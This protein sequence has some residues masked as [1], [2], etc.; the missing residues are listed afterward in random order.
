M[1]YPKGLCAVFKKKRQLIKYCNCIVILFFLFNPFTN[2]ASHIVGGEMSYRCIG[3]NNFEI[4]LTIY[5]DCYNATQGTLFDNP[6][7]IG[8]F[9]DNDSL[10]LDLMGLDS[11]QMLIPSTFSDT[12][13]IILSDPCL[14]PPENICI[15]Y[16][17]YIDT[18]FLDPDII[19]GGVQLT[20]QRCCRN[21]QIANV[22]ESD[23]TGISIVANISDE[24]IQTC[25]SSPQFS[26]LP[27]VFVCV[28]EPFVFDQSLTDVDGDSL[29][30]SLCTPLDG[31][32]LLDTRPQPP[33]NPPYD[34]ITWIDPPYNLN[35]LLGGI[36]LTIDPQTGELTATP[37]TIGLF[38]VGLCIEEYRDG[39]LISTTR[40][41][42]QYNV[43][44]CEEVVAEIATPIIE[45]DELEVEFENLSINA[46]EFLWVF[47]D[48]G[49]PN[50]TSFLENP[51]FHFSDT[52]SYTIML[53]AEPNSPCTDT[54][55]IDILLEKS[56]LEADFNH[57]TLECTDSVML[58]LV[59]TSVDSVYSIE[60]WYW[61]LSDGQTSNEQFPLFV[62]DS[63]QQLDV[64]LVVVSENGCEEK[65]EA[66]IFVNLISSNLLEDKHVICDGDS[67]VLN[68]NPPI[69][70]PFIYEWTPNDGLNDPTLASPT[71]SPDMDMDYSLLIIDTISNCF[72]ELETEVVILENPELSIEM[73]GIPCGNE[74]ELTAT[75]NLTQGDFIWATDENF[76]NIISDSSTIVVSSFG[77]TTYYVEFSSSG[78]CIITDSI[79]VQEASIN[80]SL[81]ANSQF[82]CV[83]DEAVFSATNADSL[84]EVTYTWFDGSG[85]VLDFDSLFE[86]STTEV[87]I[88]LFYFQA[89]NQHGCTY[90]DSVFLSAIDPSLPV[91]IQIT[92]SCNSNVV[93]FSNIGANANFYRWIINLPS[94]NDTLLGANIQNYDFVNSGTYE[95]TLV[96][97]PGLPCTLPT[98]TIEVTTGEGVVNA[99]FSWEYIDCQNDLMIQFIDNSSAV[100]GN[101]NSMIWTFGN[102]PPVSSSNP[103]LQLNSSGLV[104]I[105]LI[106]TTD[107][108]CSDTLYQEIDFQLTDIGAFENATVVCSGDGVTLNP[109]GN[110]SLNYEWSPANFLDDANSVSPFA[111]PPTTTI[112]TVTITDPNNPNCV[113]EEMVE[114][115]VP[116]VEVQA[117]F[118]YEI[119]NCDSTSVVLTF[120]DNSTP[121]AIINNW[122][123][124][125]SNGQSSNNPV[126]TIVANDGEVLEVTL[127]V[128][129]EDDCSA[130]IVET[131]VVETFTFNL[132]ES[133][134]IKCTGLPVVLNENGNSNFTYTWTPAATL[135]DPNSP[136]PIANP[137]E[138]TEYC[139]TVFNGECSQESCVTVIVPEVPLM[140]DF[141]YSVSDC[142]DEAVISFQDQSQNSLGNIVEWNWTFSNGT[143]STLENPSITITQD[144]IIEAVL[145]VTTSNGC[146][147]SFSQEVEVNLLNI[148]I[149]SQVVLCE[150]N[151]IQL[152]P[153]GN[154]NHEY[155]WFPGSGLTDDDVAS[156]VAFPTSTTTYTVT[157]TDGD[158]QVVQNVEVIVPTIPLTAGFSFNIEDCTDVAVIDFEDLSEYSPGNIIEWN[159]TFS[160]GDI[161]TGS[162]PSVT[163]DSSQ[164]LGVT[165]EVMTD[166]GCTAVTTQNLDINLI[167]IN[168]APLLV[169]CNG[170]GVELNPAGD[171]TYIYSWSPS[172]GL[173]NTNS[174]NPIANPTSTTLYTV[175]V[176]DGICE[177]TREVEVIVPDE[178][179]QAGFSFSFED[180]TDNAVIEFTDTTIIGNNTISEWN[181]TFTGNDT[182]TFTT[183]NPILTFNQSD[184]IIAELT[185]TTNDGC[186]ATISE[187]IE[188]NLIDINIPTE[189]IYCNTSGIILN[190]NGNP[191]YEYE[192]SPSMGL[193]A[194]NVASPIVSGLTQNMSYS[195][196]VKFGDCIL[197]RNVNVII[198][199]VPVQADFNFTYLTCIDSAT[200]Q[201]ND[202]SQYSG[203]IIEWD[204]LINSQASNEPNPIF[205]FYE[206]QPFNVQLIVTTDNGCRDTINNT[207]FVSLMDN[208]NLPTDTA[209]CNGNGIFLN[210]NSSNPGVDYVW[211]PGIGLSGDTLIANP[212]AN[213]DSSQV[214]T[215]TLTSPETGCVEER[216]IS[217][218][219]PTQPLTAGFEWE[220]SN[221]SDSSVVEFIDTS[222]Y[223]GIL[224]E[225]TWTFDNTNVF[226]E[227]NPD[228]V[229]FNPD[230]MTVQLVVTSNDGCI[231]S[232]ETLVPIE[233]IQIPSLDDSITLCNDD[234]VFL[235]PNGNPDLFYTWSP[236]GSLD[237]TNFY[238]PLATPL[239]STQYF[240]TITS[241]NNI[242]CNE[243]RTVDVLV[244]SNPIDLNWIYPTD[245]IICTPLLELTAQSNNAA[246]FIWSDQSDFQ[247]VLGVDPEFMAIPTNE[248]TFYLQVID[249][250]GCFL[251]DSITITSQAILASLE[252]SRSICYGDSTQ[253]EVIIN[254]L[255]GAADIEYTWMPQEGILLDEETGTPLLSP[256]D[257]TVYTLLMENQFGCI[258]EDT[259]DIN[260]LDLATLIE[261]GIDRDSINAGDEIQLFTTESSN[262]IYSWSPCE[263]LSGC[264]I[265]NPVATPEVTTT[266]TVTIEDEDL[267]CLYED[268]V[269]VFV[270]DQSRCQEPFVFVPKGFTPNDDGLNDIL[271]V[272]GNYIEEMEFVVF[273]RWGEKVF[274]TKDLNEGWDGKVNG[275]IVPPDVFGYYVSLKCFG[276]EEYLM[277]GNVTLIR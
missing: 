81:V 175:T 161:L 110:Q 194:T 248:S 88:E 143:T 5:R 221:C 100:Q 256:L 222:T 223:S 159:W 207:S 11:G 268:S 147:A 43:G 48:P 220:Y 192:W 102:N 25:N 233:V 198:P 146:E 119:V 117:A 245:T 226:N 173:T 73:T 51:S 170:V 94:G 122:F 38:L 14:F 87:G 236:G 135:N 240:V 166:D 30:Y 67:V 178:P 217:L 70:L 187:E 212:F 7:S 259:I 130:I 228:S 227:Q 191:S 276:G 246:Q 202:I 229:F 277:K 241:P 76:N 63:A 44:V 267:G 47:N 68:V 254:P 108:G 120:T 149:P 59:D 124:Q 17:T 121:S 16:M 50:D 92:Q 136:N 24:A 52:G 9:G 132:P 274:E 216:T 19:Q 214:Y 152:N 163:I 257:S 129:T 91:D 23:T 35:N 15:E 65:K 148:Q 206:T 211:N 45:C 219:V 182:T 54:T 10:I 27:P 22:F 32:A 86:I 231:D 41:E 131:I 158:C 167:D 239:A 209:T 29:V 258:Y 153:N 95:I 199:D 127:Q 186:V 190:P 75:T 82:V 195:V 62:L 138:T 179:I 40:R 184:T 18:I 204:W 213:P 69:G 203:N 118:D 64:K 193:S 31:A 6:A 111:S 235:N 90:L 141:S 253:L 36:P 232:I 46:Q 20:Y 114:V 89:E 61:E 185:V 238:N 33:Y 242:A 107:E 60:S 265:S 181:W 151:P 72:A 264:D 74:T 263:G 251:T 96:P 188:V 1:I 125:F 157:V 57:L 215:V 183:Q 230:T 42:F 145:E 83:G 71:A 137:V 160:N 80:V 139:V 134:I 126:T 112:F 162:N 250:V 113:I 66:T 172:N 262:W 269:S 174:P 200:L 260:V 4:S 164:T 116:E 12:L 168:V 26:V 208:I 197:N 85:N 273:N 58:A 210:P 77:Q 270:F 218:N 79:T 244:P 104:P 171:P 53:I 142:I 189:V 55:Y 133:E 237:T 3:E 13:D 180:C 169:N 201:F 109:L 243:V 140:A 144:S 176:T 21:G 247:N 105:E 37:N 84:D 123:W 150:G 8:V 272:R 275:K 39:I 56:S 78:S 177:F 225:W 49:N 98:E 28:N 261:V 252:E 165:L 115:V 249:S 128:Q 255:S 34:E 2:F 234:S 224:S 266:Y 106:V 103:I 205:V 93:S 271:Y 101:I 154:P 155:S 99:G 156:P 196:I 97:I